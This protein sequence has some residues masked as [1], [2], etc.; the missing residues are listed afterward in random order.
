M[1]ENCKT[2]YKDF[3]CYLINHHEIVI[4]SKIMKK[5]INENLKKRF[6]N[7]CNV[8]NPDINKFV[9]MLLK[10][11]YSY[12]QERSEDT[13]SVAFKVL[14]INCQIYFINFFS[15]NYWTSNFCFQKNIFSASRREQLLWTL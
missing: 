9:L 5:K 6:T 15:F 11:I 4:K 7:T 2:K 13:S 3:K 12:E 1:E 8:W 14:V 10:I